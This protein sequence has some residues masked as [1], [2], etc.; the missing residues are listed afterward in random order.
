MTVHIVKAVI[1]AAFSGLTA[2]SLNIGYAGLV[3]MFLSASLTQAETTLSGSFK[4]K[5][6]SSKNF[7]GDDSGDWD[8][9]AVFQETVLNFNSPLSDSFTLTGGVIFSGHWGESDTIGQFGTDYV[10]MNTDTLFATITH[11]NW[12]LRLGKQQYDM[13]N[14][15]LY[16]EKL[17]GAS[18]SYFA[19]SWAIT[20]IAIDTDSHITHDLF[21][22]KGEY[23]PNPF[24]SI[25]PYCLLASGSG[26]REYYPGIDIN[27][28]TDTSE[29]WFT[30]IR[31]LG[32]VDI[33]DRHFTHDGCLSVFEHV[34]FTEFG[35][36]R[37]EWIYATGGT[38]EN[39]IKAFQGTVGQSYPWSEIMGLGDLDF[40]AS[41]GAPGEYLTNIR[42]VNVG[43]SYIL[44]NG[45]QTDIDLWYAR[46]N[47]ERIPEAPDWY[48]G[49]ELGFEID[50]KLTYTLAESMKAEMI[51]AYLFAGNATC[52]RGNKEN[53]YEAGLILSVEF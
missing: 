43:G 50:V 8:K 49:K 51:F 10:G 42:A 38:E 47:E 21:G 36:I 4:V 37:T 17:T 44:K 18:G 53:P 48:N 14:G 29:S 45:F 2:M 11:G 31:Q 7:T 28:K 16:S 22:L 30:L 1:R 35:N 34:R 25:F 20:A 12:E 24:V 33:A 15:L 5:S 32:Y 39:T 40:G 19:D 3:I 23:H 6:Y 13:A 41:Y 26:R 46:L 27:F 9:A 52:N